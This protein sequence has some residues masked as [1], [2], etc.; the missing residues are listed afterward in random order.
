MHRI[1]FI[2]FLTPFV[3]FGQ[4]SAVNEHVII[5]TLE[6]ESSL[7]SREFGGYD[8]LLELYY[9][10]VQPDTLY[11]EHKVATKTATGYAY[12]WL[13]A[14]TSEP[15]DTS[16]V[17]ILD[18]FYKSIKP[19][20]ANYYTTYRLRRGSLMTGQTVWFRAAYYRSRP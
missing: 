11:L 16:G 4:P 12:T 7:T 13:P 9:P 5:D 1:F 6:S 3:A 2:L 15:A 10:V 17:I 18:G 8:L 14:A 19:A 20:K